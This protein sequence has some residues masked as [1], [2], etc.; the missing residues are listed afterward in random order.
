MSDPNS[1]SIIMIERLRS[2]VA[3]LRNYIQNGG[4]GFSVKMGYYVYVLERRTVGWT[5]Y[6]KVEEENYHYKTIVCLDFDEEDK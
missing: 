5:F 2:I 1:D 6:K 3:I 4:K